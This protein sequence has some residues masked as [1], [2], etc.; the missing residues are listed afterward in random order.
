MGL[1]QGK[2]DVTNNETGF[3]YIKLLPLILL[4]IALAIFFYFGLEKYLSFEALQQHRNFLAKFTT[5]NYLETVLIFMFIYI[6][7]IAISVPGA[8]IL[9]VAAGFMF[10][11]LWGTCYV[12]FSATVGATIVFLAAR[13]AL[14]DLLA[15]KAGNFVQQLKKGFRKNEFN[16]LLILRLIPLF[17]FW[18][19]NIIPALLKVRID[20]FVTATFLGIIPGSIVYASIGN[21]LDHLLQQNQE[22]NLAM[23]FQPS[24]LLPILGLALLTLLP[25][26]YKQFRNNS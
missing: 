2:S 19:I 26:I 3:S 12:V 17:P 25:I 21:G 15:L 7:A 23:I 24:L 13:T 8:A 9:T 4:L 14:G 20:T 1:P 18:L 22:P 11:I 6:M 16:Y 10:G 5:D